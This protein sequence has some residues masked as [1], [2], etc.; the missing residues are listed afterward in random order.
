MIHVDIFYDYGAQRD[1]GH[2]GHQLRHPQTG[3]AAAGLRLRLPLQLLR[4]QRQGLQLPIRLESRRRPFTPP[5][6]AVWIERLSASPGLEN[7]DGPGNKMEN[8]PRPYTPI[9]GTTGTPTIWKWYGRMAH[10][11][12]AIRNPDQT[13]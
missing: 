4:A 13:S 3:A 6:A 11:A 7:Y 2:A 10:N 5:G 1:A 9:F 8:P 12:F